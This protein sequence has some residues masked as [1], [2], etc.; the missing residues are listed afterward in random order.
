M[1][2]KR[3]K[4]HDEKCLTEYNIVIKYGLKN[5]VYLRFV[6]IFHFLFLLII[7][8]SCFFQSF[9]LSLFL[10]YLFTCYQIFIMY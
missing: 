10:R 8:L 3:K 6:F 7:F 9:F 5:S 2:P 4:N 1:E